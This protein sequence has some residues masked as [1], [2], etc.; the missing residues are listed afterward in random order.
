VAVF[1]ISGPSMRQARPER[2]LGH[3][4]GVDAALV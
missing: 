1:S 3:S 4:Q 2:Y